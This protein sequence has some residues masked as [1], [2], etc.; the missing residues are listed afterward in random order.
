MKRMIQ[1]LFSC[2]GADGGRD[3]MEMENLHLSAIY[4]A[5]RDPHNNETKATTLELLKAK[6]IR[7]NSSRR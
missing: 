1:V 6:T 2:E 3:R 7:L 4:D 5:L